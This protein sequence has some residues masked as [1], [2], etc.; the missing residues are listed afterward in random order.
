[1]QCV[2]PKWT[3]F[4]VLA[5]CASVSKLPSYI[6]IVTQKIIFSSLIFLI[7]IEIFY[8]KYFF[9][10]P[11]GYVNVIPTQCKTWTV[12][13]K[14]SWELPQIWKL[15]LNG[16]NLLS[17]KCSYP[18]HLRIGKLLWNLLGNFLKTGHFIGERKCTECERSRD[19]L[20]RETIST[21]DAISISHRAATGGSAQ[22][23][24][25]PT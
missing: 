19:H 14:Q 1:M 9:F 10:R 11:L 20:H 4:S 16:F 5:H 6:E 24:A 18:P 25:R 22:H 2:L 23:V 7:E 17:I 12:S 21:R 8:N 13:L 15:G 3:F